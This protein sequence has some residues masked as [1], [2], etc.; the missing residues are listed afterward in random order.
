MGPTNSIMDFKLG[1][2]EM[3]KTTLCTQPQANTRG[4]HVA[5]YVAKHGYTAHCLDE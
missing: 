5:K 2:M 1:C 3:C 4:E